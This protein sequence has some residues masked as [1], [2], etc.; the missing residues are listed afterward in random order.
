MRFNSLE[1][2]VKY[3]VSEPINLEYTDIVFENVTDKEPTRTEIFNKELNKRL[4]KED[5]SSKEDDQSVEENL[6]VKIHSFYD[7]P[8]IDGSFNDENILFVEY[9]EGTRDF[10]GAGKVNLLGREIMTNLCE[11]DG[12]AYVKL[13]IDINGKIL[14]NV[15]FKLQAADADTKNKIFIRKDILND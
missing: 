4:N 3:V 14:E 5:D 10:C 7:S 1:E 6:E 12:T 8:R 15:Q 2:L 13:S 9:V 11:S